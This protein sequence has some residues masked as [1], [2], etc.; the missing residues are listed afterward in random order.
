MYRFRNESQFPLLNRFTSVLFK[1]TF[2]L[3]KMLTLFTELQKDFTH[4]FFIKQI[5]AQT[6]M[7]HW[8]WMWTLSAPFVTGWPKLVSKRTLAYWLTLPSALDNW[9]TPS[10]DWRDLFAFCSVE[11]RCHVHPCTH[12][13][14]RYLS[15]EVM[16]GCDKHLI[17]IF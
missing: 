16:N 15:Y 10:I 6:L 13:G 1:E 12:P 8:G 9:S 11:P 7:T 14:H 3:I 2:M 4:F 5:T 17:F